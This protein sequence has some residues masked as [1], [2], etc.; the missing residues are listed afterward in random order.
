MPDIRRYIRY[1]MSEWREEGDQNACPVVP[2]IVRQYYA[3]VHAS[4]PWPEGT[5]G[6][7]DVHDL[8]RLP[9]LIF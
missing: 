7:F 5:I 9:T 4:F 3:D 2:E 1:T 8:A 6:R